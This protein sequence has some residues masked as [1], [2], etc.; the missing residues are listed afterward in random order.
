[1]RNNTCHVPCVHTAGKGTFRG[2]EK[3]PVENAL[4]W[5]YTSRTSSS[6]KT[7]NLE[8]FIRKCCPNGTSH[9][10][11]KKLIFISLKFKVRPGTEVRERGEGPVGAEQ[12]KGYTAAESTLLLASNPSKLEG[13]RSTQQIPVNQFRTLTDSYFSSKLPHHSVY[14]LLHSTHLT[15]ECKLK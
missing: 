2:R 7:S 4:L 6:G 14:C 10:S 9:T 13:A 1:M 3:A 11:Y 12:V 8:A 5:A 15:S